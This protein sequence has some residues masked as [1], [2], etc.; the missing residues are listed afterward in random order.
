MRDHRITLGQYQE[1]PDQIRFRK[2]NFPNRSNAHWALEVKKR[3][4]VR[5]R[6]PA[7]PGRRGARASAPAPWPAR[8]QRRRP[9]C[10]CAAPRPARPPSD[11]APAHTKLGHSRTAFGRHSYRKCTNLPSSVC[12][13]GLWRS[14]VLG[15]A[16]L[17]PRTPNLVVVST[18]VI[19]F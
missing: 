10:S 12:C 18:P 19:D 17:S 8:R 1:H 13:T 6:A 2:V 14:L 3:R 11:R 7:G 9:S 15:A 5:Q 4:D 16:C